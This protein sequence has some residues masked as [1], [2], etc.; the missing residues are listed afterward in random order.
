MKVHNILTL[1]I[2]VLSNILFNV[3]ATGLNECPNEKN[4]CSGEYEATSEL[5]YNYCIIK[6]SKDNKDNY[7]KICKVE[8]VTSKTGSSKRETIT[9]KYTFTPVEAS[10][11]AY[12]F[13]SGNLVEDKNTLTEYALKKVFCSDYEE[14]LKK[15]SKEV[16]VTWEKLIETSKH[17]I[18]N[19]KNNTNIIGYNG[20]FDD[21]E[22]GLYSIYEFIYSCR[23]SP[24]LPFPEI[25]SETSIN[26]LTLMRKIKDEI[27]SDDIFRS[28]IDFTLE[29]LNGTNVVFFKW[30][31]NSLSS[32][33][34]KN[35]KM[36]PLPGIKEGISGGTI[37]GYNLCI[38][39]S[40]SKKKI[41]A[42][43][44]ALKYLTSK[45]LQKKYMLSGD[46]MSG[47]SSFYDDE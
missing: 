10:E 6:N 12:V 38:D 24:D 28:N 16:P 42:A 18:E 44:E 27:S 36:S 32:Y 35:Y 15:Y 14:L 37:K 7:V 11:N 25:K 5:S 23:E 29:R 41:D 46:L 26:A 47:I 19:E 3:N 8:D 39:G 21:S 9:N 43:I 13:K 22:Q 31:S 30:Y 1:G 34:S 33:D 17:I 45:E 2:F 20:L 4:E 40:I